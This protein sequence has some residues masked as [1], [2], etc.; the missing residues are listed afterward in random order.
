M[1]KMSSFLRYKI[2][3]NWQ[4]LLGPRQV[5]SPQK[6]HEKCICPGLLTSLGKNCLVKKKKTIKSKQ[7]QSIFLNY[8]NRNICTL[9][10]WIIIFYLIIFDISRK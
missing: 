9:S 6:V 3:I 5:P 2:K 8:I 4:G 7:L 1:H 10:K